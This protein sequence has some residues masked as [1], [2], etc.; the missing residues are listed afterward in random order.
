MFAENLP[1]LSRRAISLMAVTIQSNAARAPFGA[2]I[3]GRFLPLARDGAG[4]RFLSAYILHMSL[5]VAVITQ[6]HP[7]SCTRRYRAR[8]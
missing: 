4:A 3:I 5:I 1:R 2:L 6:L 7:P 8:A